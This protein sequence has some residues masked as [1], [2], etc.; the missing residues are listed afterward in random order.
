MGQS[1]IFQFPPVENAIL[2]HTRVPQVIC[3]SMVQRSPRAEEFIFRHAR[4]FPLPHGSKK[5]PRALHQLDDLAFA[6][7]VEFDFV[8]P[9]RRLVDSKLRSGTAFSQLQRPTT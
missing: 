4:V 2:H 5:V 3:R 6:L 9:F 1:F 8:I 7:H